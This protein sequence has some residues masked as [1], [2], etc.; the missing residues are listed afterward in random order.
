MKDY[1]LQAVVASE[2]DEEEVSEILNR[3]MSW[4][5]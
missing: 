3:L 5:V 4:G 2:V 1:V